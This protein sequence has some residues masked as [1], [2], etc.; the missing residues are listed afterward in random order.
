MMMKTISSL[1]LAA[2]L[3]ASLMGSTALAGDVAPGARVDTVFLPKFLGILPFD[4][5][6]RGAQE[7]A[8]WS[9][10]LLGYLAYCAGYALASGA[11]KGEIGDSFT[12]GR[13]GPYTIEADP[14]RDGAKRILMGPF[15]VYDKDN[16]EAAA[17]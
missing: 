12:A 15:T 1:A 16:V 2:G 14:G 7:F 6:C 11:I 3:A 4:Q 5:A 10:V 17:K 13:M 9:F 8:L